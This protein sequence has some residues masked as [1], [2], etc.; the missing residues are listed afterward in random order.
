[1]F[2]ETEP[3]SLS[4]DS[5]AC[6]FER[7]QG[8]CVVVEPSPCRN[9]YQAEVGARQQDLPGFRACLHPQLTLQYLF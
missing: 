8:L 1:M 3:S 7:V 9:A 4:S 5:R 6:K 2:S